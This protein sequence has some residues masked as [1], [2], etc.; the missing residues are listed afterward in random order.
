VSGGGAGRPSTSEGD[1]RMALTN[2]AFSIAQ[3]EAS[4]ENPSIPTITRTIFKEL[5][6]MS[7][8]VKRFE[9]SISQS[10]AFQDQ[11]DK[12]Q[13]ELLAMEIQRIDEDIRRRV[14]HKALDKLGNKFKVCTRSLMFFSEA[15]V[16]KHAHCSIG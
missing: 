2:Q 14:D 9:D 8:R 13:D 5:T 3:N 15:Y 4:K 12:A 11:K 6:A 16:D 10:M 7:A 1:K